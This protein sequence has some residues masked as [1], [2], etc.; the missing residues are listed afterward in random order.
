M[1]RT[2]ASPKAKPK[3]Q[4]FRTFSEFYPFYLGEHALPLTKLFHAAGSL[5]VLYILFSSLLTGAYGNLMYM[6]LAGYGFAWI[7]HAL[8]ERNKPATFTYPLWSFCGDWVMLFHLLTG[9]IG[10]SDTKL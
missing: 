5:L 6:P 2:A 3:A 9:R 4:R 10:L 1:T 7:S 8:I